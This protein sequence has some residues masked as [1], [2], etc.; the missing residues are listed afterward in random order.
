MV[1][2]SGPYAL[3]RNLTEMRTTP[4]DVDGLTQTFR[5]KVALA[6]PSGL[7]LEPAD[8]GLVDVEVV[9]EEKEVAKSFDVPIEGRNTSYPY[10]I[11]PSSIHIRIEGPASTIEELAQTGGELQAYTD[12]KGLCPG[13]YVRKCAISLPL[14]ASLIDAEPEVF[15]I[16]ITENMEE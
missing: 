11:T 4:I 8:L 6:L 14:D 16:N 2:V 1:E 15:T 12:L 9:I 10:V 5:K 3:I 7:H 13:V